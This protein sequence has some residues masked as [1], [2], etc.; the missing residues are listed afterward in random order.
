[1]PEFKY[2]AINKSGES[3]AGTITVASQADVVQMLRDKEY[4]PISVEAVRKSQDIN[5]GF[6]TKIKIKD[7]A[8][9]CRQ[10]HTNCAAAA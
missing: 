3:L 10:F 9:F 6:L 1:M 8:I 7:I 4:M 2:R 5:I